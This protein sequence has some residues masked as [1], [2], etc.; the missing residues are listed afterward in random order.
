MADISP[1]L[2]SGMRVLEIGCAEGSLGAMVRDSVAVHYT[3][4]KLSEDATSAVS[5]DDIFGAATP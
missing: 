2:R 5:L 4:I 1:L 3:G